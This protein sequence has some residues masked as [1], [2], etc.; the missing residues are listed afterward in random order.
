MVE[1]VKLHRGMN[2]TSIFFHVT[3]N[4]I[5]P[6]IK[7]GNKEYRVVISAGFAMRIQQ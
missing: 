5:Y 3:Q 2:R 4:D 6:V 1:Y 7:V